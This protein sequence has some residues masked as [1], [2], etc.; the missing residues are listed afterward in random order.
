M[1]IGEE[2]YNRVE[3]NMERN[4]GCSTW[5]KEDQRVGIHVFNYMKD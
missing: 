1:V 5:T 4:Y 2:M 3:V